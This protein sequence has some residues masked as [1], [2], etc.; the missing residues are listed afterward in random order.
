MRIVGVYLGLALLIFSC[1]K[2]EDRTCF[3]STGKEVTVDVKLD[4][5]L[6]LYLLQ[7][8]S[9]HLVPDTVNFARITGGENLINHVSFNYF[10]SILYV[11]NDNKCNFLRSYDKTIR[12]EIHYTQLFSTKFIGSETL[13]N[14]DSIRGEHFNLYV[15]KGS[16][17]VDL[18]VYNDFS[19]ALVGDGVGD[20]TLRGKVRYGHY[21]IRDNGF[22]DVTGVIASEG[23]KISTTSAGIMKCRADGI[24]LVVNIDGPGDVWYYGTPSSI[25]LNKS[26]D[27][28]LIH[29][30]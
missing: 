6:G 26:G 25:T 18:T 21:Q 2:S 12:V 7:N 17:S 19:N 28:N 4:G 3:K 29:K 22:A 1:K 13:T 27:G 16:G 20:Y 5:F 24:P 9:Y 15:D 14:S 30:N 23:L 11:I 8:L 10:D